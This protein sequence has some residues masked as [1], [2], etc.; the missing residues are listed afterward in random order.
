MSLHHISLDRYIGIGSPVHLLRTD[1]KLAAVALVIV[2]VATTSASH[3]W[4]FASAAGVLSVAAV[5]S[6]IPLLYLLRRML[7]L[8]FFVVGVAVLSLLQP[9]GLLVFG[10]L[11]VKSTLCLAAA[12]LFSAT[13]PFSAILLV[14]RRWKVPSLLVTLIALMYRYV[15]VLLD[16]LGRMQRARASR[17]FRNARLL[18]WRSPATLVAQL[19][20]RSTE[21]AEKIFAAMAAR[22]WK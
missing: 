2:I 18:A 16:E 21:R 20:I 11:L 19:F 3:A 15:F 9:G 8:E 7:V 14:L 4:V 17:T 6:R 5:L 10:T 22:G 12:V 1:A 13:T